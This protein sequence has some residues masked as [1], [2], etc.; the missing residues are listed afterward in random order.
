LMK[1]IGANNFQVATQFLAEAGIVGF[2]GGLLGFPIGYF[3]AG[4]IANNI[5]GVPISTFDQT[6]LPITLI[7][8]ISISLVGSVIPM[9]KAMKIEPAAVLRGE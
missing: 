5:F 3:L 2:L 7:V 4:F 8:A 6:I 9:R 1:A